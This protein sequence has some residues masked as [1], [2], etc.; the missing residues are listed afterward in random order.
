MHERGVD[1]TLLLQ[2][3]CWHK[4]KKEEDQDTIP[5][6]HQKTDDIFRTVSRRQ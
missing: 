5:V 1:E 2:K 6:A 3:A 4:Q